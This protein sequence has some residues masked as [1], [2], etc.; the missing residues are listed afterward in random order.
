MR[1]I[2]LGKE[3]LDIELSVA[4]YRICG[5][6]GGGT[7][8]GFSAFAEQIYKITEEHPMPMERRIRLANIL[9]GVPAF[10]G[11]K[12]ISDL[13][14]PDFP[15]TTN[16]ADINEEEKKR[17]R[18]TICAEWERANPGY[19]ISFY[20][21][22]GNLLCSADCRMRVLTL[23]DAC[24]EIHM[25]GTIV[26]FDGKQQ[27]K[28]FMAA[29]SSMRWLCP[30]ERKASA[31]EF[32]EYVRKLKAEYKTLTRKTRPRIIFAD[33]KGKKLYSVR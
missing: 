21:E 1:V 19:P 5:D 13:R 9:S 30:E 31:E 8:T 23:S 24:L 26:R 17:V 10:S 14:D 18:E 7:G 20:D 33:D 22:E 2:S 6:L 16:L 27:K 28:R 32:D 15:Y 12:L 11:D 29:A 3:N 4:S 25:D